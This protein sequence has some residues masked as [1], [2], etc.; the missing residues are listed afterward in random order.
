GLG[1]GAKGMRIGVVQE[2]FGHPNSEPEVDAKVRAAANEFAKLGATVDDVS[3]PM[4]LAGGA[5]W[6]PIALE[7]ATELMMKGNGFGTNWRGLFVTSLLDAHSGWG[8]RA[9]E[10][11]DTLEVSMLLGH[12]VVKHDRGHFYANARTLR[13]KLR[14]AA[15]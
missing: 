4:H 13:A 14:A 8:H 9:D 7:G 3:V 11:P 2:G 6:T 15:T 12:C 1:Q 10:L 5:I